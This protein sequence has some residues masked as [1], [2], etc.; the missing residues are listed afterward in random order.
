MSSV[1]L[2]HTHNDKKFA[3]KIT[4]DLRKHGHI[5]W[6]DEA[7]I[8]VGDSLVEKIREGIDRVDYIVAVISEKSINSEWVKKE[9]DLATNREISEKRV[10][11]LPLLLDDVEL[12]GF[13]KGKL[14]ADFRNES[15][16]DDSLSLLLRKLGA[17]SSA[18]ELNKDEREALRIE[19]EQLRKV[20]EYHYRNTERQRRLSA[21]NKSNNLQ[22]AIESE[23]SHHPEWALINDTYAF[24][25]MGCPITL[26]YVLH[27]ISK[28]QMRGSHVL[29]IML[30]MENKWDN[31]LLLLEA[32]ADYNGFP[33][34]SNLKFNDNEDEEDDEY[35]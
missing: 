28:A 34:P 35:Y 15:A 31:L 27:A 16:Y 13:L 5:V 14:F 7:E 21:L 33:P 2:S 11:V 23:N 8:E 10:I 22:Q 1:F 4:A 12:P 6:I 26:G 25:V 30:S 19:I 9:L 18:P 3:R 17:G 32:F 29:E 20:A 24:E